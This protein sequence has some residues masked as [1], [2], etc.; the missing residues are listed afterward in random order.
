[1]SIVIRRATPADAPAL[2]AMVDALCAADDEPRGHF[3]LERAVAHGFGDRPAFSA[4]LAELEGRLAGYA[5]F[6]PI[7]ATEWGERGVYMHDLWVEPH[8]RRRGVA[9]CLVAGVAAEART[10]GG[11]FVWWC[12]K[13]NNVVANRFY[14]S[15]ADIHETVRAHALARDA[16][17]RL[18]DEGRIVSAATR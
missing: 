10:G 17:A 2:V 9:R 4:L 3:T 5:T 12:S 13:P 11:T 16:F 1:M 14:E 8:A 6:E 15:I 7:Y 18:A